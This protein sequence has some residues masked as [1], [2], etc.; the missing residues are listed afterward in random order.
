MILDGN[1]FAGGAAVSERDVSNAETAN[2]SSDVDAALKRFGWKGE[3]AAAI[4]LALNGTNTG[5]L[6]GRVVIRG[7][8][9]EK[10]CKVDAVKI[11]QNAEH[12]TVLED[13]SMFNFS[14]GGLSSGYVD[15]EAIVHSFTAAEEGH[16]RVLLAGDLEED[17]IGPFCLRM[18]CQLS[19]DCSLDRGIW[20]SYA[21]L[22]FPGTV[23]EMAAR[24]PVAVSPNWPGIK[25]AEGEMPVLP[26]P[27]IAWRCPILPL[28]VPGTP[29][30]VE[31]TAPSAQTL[32]VAVAGIMSRA[33]APDACKNA[34]SLFNKWAKL[35]KRREVLRV[36][37]PAVEWPAADQFV[38]QG[39]EV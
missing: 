8:P 9:I 17:G 24:G 15:G 6:E 31:P 27:S 23:A 10:T 7:K 20:L 36:K 22:L 3:L 35:E 4:V 12:G 13:F 30:D 33:V 18:I 5:V 28:L 29:F 21:V 14:E 38:E 2:Y 26:K 19:K 34:A 25:V 16:L 11:W 1:L 37:E 39:N 32:R